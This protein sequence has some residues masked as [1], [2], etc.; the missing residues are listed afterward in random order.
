MYVLTKLPCEP[1]LYEVLMN[2]ELNDLKFNFKYDRSDTKVLSS[3]FQKAHLKDYIN[4][5]QSRKTLKTTL[6]AILSAFQKQI[7]RCAKSE[8]LF[9]TAW[10][11]IPKALKA[12]NV[13][14]SM[15]KKMAN[16]KSALKCGEKKFV[17]KELTGM[18]PQQEKKK[19]YLANGTSD[20]AKNCSL[21]RR[22]KKGNEK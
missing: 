3:F 16:I 7:C 4:T 5:A 9:I 2:K 19:L 21:R 6:T 20:T 10:Q 15:R 13:R 12:K 11:A 1:N 22:D 17:R 18:Q 8:R 14:L